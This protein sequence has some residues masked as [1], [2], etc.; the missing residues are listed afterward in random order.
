[1]MMM[2]MGGVRFLGYPKY[3]A[4]LDAFDLRVTSF[5]SWF[6]INNFPIHKDDFTSKTKENPSRNRS[7]EQQA[8]ATNL[9]ENGLADEVLF[10]RPHG[11]SYW[12]VWDARKPYC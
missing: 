1:M 10:Q 6:P 2:M 4:L 5:P 9:L 8:G 11:F 12:F 3:A 7:G